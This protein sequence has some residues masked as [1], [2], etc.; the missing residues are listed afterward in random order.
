[1]KSLFSAT[2]KSPVSGL[3]QSIR[4][5][6]YGSNLCCECTLCS[7]LIIHTTM[8]CEGAADF[9]ICLLMLRFLDLRCLRRSAFCLNDK[10]IYFITTQSTKRTATSFSITGAT[11]I[12]NVFSRDPFFGRQYEP[13]PPPFRS[14][15]GSFESLTSA[16]ARLRRS[17]RAGR[18]PSNRRISPFLDPIPPV[19]GFEGFPSR[20]RGSFDS[21]CRMLSG[22][23][24]PSRRQHS[25]RGSEGGVG[26]GAQGIRRERGR[27]GVPGYRF[28]KAL[29]RGG[30]SEAVQVVQHQATGVLY[31]EKRVRINRDPHEKIRAIAEVNALRMV[32]GDNLNYMKDRYWSSSSLTI[33]LEYCSAGSLEDRITGSTH[34]TSEAFCWHTLMGLAKALTF[35]HY[36]TRDALREGPVKDWNALWH[37]DIKPCNVFLSTSG[38]RGPYPRIVL[39]DFG[40]AVS[41]SDILEGRE[42]PQRQP[43]ITRGWEPE[44]YGRYYGS[45]TDIFMM[46]GVVHCLAR[47]QPVK[48]DRHRLQSRSPCGSSYSPQLNETVARGAKRDWKQRHSAADVVRLVAQYTNV[49]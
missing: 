32:K 17:S 43:A 20:R 22:G 48:P 16:A 34:A 8:H 23:R 26:L 18:P 30:M 12:M 4:K 7:R 45:R 11:S 33:I 28:V 19:V 41:A 49:R 24:P 10:R 27:C 44:E 39:G 31:V 9:H 37:L 42:D 13:L 1:M 47:M 36:G 5:P 46:S 2:F 21:F 14:R 29:G 40:C 38:Q 3:Q 6:W 15:G 35:L 25:R